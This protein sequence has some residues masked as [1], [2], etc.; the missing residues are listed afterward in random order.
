[1]LK[2]IRNHNKRFYIRLLVANKLIMKK[3][4]FLLVFGISMNSLFAQSVNFGVKGGLNES[5][6][7]LTG[8]ATR[9]S[10]LAGFNAGLFADV[11]IKQLTIEP[12]IFY[13]NKGYN[14]YT[15][16]TSNSEAGTY[17]F[18]AQGNITLNYLE[19][20]VNILYNIRFKQGKFF[21]GGG[22]YYGLALSGKSNVTTTSGN[23]NEIPAV[24][25]SGGN[26]TIGNTAADALKRSD[27]GLNALAGIKLNNGLL[28][29]TG[30]GFGFTDIFNRDGQGIQNRVLNVSAG[31]CFL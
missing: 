10:N 13:T 25:N 1:M 14:S 18:K 22:P 5:T 29:S 23:E 24:T 21:I 16:V 17:T 28:I 12:G 3:I 15:Y 4:F 31:Y 11:N 6:A 9:F 20:P 8:S 19:V 7:T 26:I 2:S 30:Y 27:F